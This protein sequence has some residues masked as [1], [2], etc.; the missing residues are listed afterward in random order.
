MLSNLGERMAF[1][2]KKD[3][4]EAVL[5][6]DIGFFDEHRTGEVINRYI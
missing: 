2:M 5:K 6:Q 4:F 3:L 1:N